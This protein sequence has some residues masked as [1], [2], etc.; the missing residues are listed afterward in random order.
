MSD[1]LNNPH[2]KADSPNLGNDQPNLGKPAEGSASKKWKIDKSDW[3]ASAVIAYAQ[4]EESYDYVKQQYNLEC[5]QGSKH[6]AEVQAM[7]RE[8]TAERERADKLSERH[9]KLKAAS[10]KQSKIFE[11]RLKETD[12]LKREIERLNGKFQAYA[13]TLNE[14]AKER[15]EARAE[16]E[17]LTRELSNA[18]KFRRAILDK[19]ASHD[20]GA[21]AYSVLREERDQLK[22]ECERIQYEARKSAHDVI[23]Y[24]SRLEAARAS[25]NAHDKSRANVLMELSAER[26]RADA[27]EARVKDLTEQLDWSLKKEAQLKE[28]L[29]TQHEFD[30]KRITEL[31]AQVL[32]VTN[33]L[34][35]KSARVESLELYIQ[36][37]QTANVPHN[38][39][40]HMLTENALAAKAKE[41]TVE[42]TLT[43]KDIKW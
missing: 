24:R 35:E 8:L 27:A 14:A 41:Q 28:Q 7:Q 13:V 9:D 11:G 16:V 43:K 25:M 1:E 19:A 26:A 23:A 18:K 39:A 6:T 42:E 21:M 38:G 12:D 10:A 20:D 3:S 17:R 40:I 31:E 22:A 34:D 36:R 37:I 2:G 30:K 32:D 15:D 5:D 4:L 29:F 33:R